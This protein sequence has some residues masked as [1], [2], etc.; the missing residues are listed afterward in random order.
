LVR[1]PNIGLGH[2][3]N[4]GWK[5]A[6]GGLVSF[7]DDD[8]YLTQT[9]VD[10]VVEVFRSLPAVG[11][12]AGHISLFDPGDIRLTVDGRDRARV[13]RPYRF[14]P[15]GSLHGANLT[16]RREVL[17]G[18]GGFDPSLGAGSSFEA[19][20]DI[21]AVARAVWAGV[22]G[23]Y[24]PRPHVF[25]HHRR[26]TSN[27]RRAVLRR[28]D[29]GRGAYYASLMRH[30]GARSAYLWGWIST[31]LAGTIISARPGRPIRELTAAWRFGRAHDEGPTR[32]SPN[33]PDG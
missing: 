28:Y 22:P 27:D 6:R 15:A 16:F 14:V 20:E 33:A 23:V 31:T 5:A 32:G 1:E 17:E 19:G 12:V 2:A 26:R 3:R 4:A 29:V 21:E 9:F 10:D 25:H 11:F 8:C 24:D 7:V 30:P 18:I 13:F